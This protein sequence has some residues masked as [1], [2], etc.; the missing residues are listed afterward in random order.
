ML[1]PSWSFQTLS[2]QIKLQLLY[3]NLIYM[4]CNIAFWETPTPQYI[5]DFR[6]HIVSLVGDINHPI[7]VWVVPT[8]EHIY[9]YLS[10]HLYIH[11]LTRIDLVSSVASLCVSSSR[12]LRPSPRTLLRVA[13]GR[14]Q[15]RCGAHLPSAADLAGE[16]LAGANHRLCHARPHGLVNVDGSWWK[17]RLVRAIVTARY[18]GCQ[19]SLA[20]QIDQVWSLIGLRSFGHMMSCMSK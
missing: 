6:S 17:L 4:L 20:W 15:Q 7:T 18:G 14:R 1:Q 10:L 16:R 9:I 8:N 12:S 13:G 19:K 3:V 11:L 2:G 5:S